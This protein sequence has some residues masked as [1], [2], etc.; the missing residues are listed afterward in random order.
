M[1]AAGLPGSI[2]CLGL[3]PACG[4]IYLIYFFLTLPMR[5][6]ERARMFLDLLELGL[7]EGRTPEAAVTGCRRHRDRSLGVR[8]HLLAAHLEQGMRLSQALEQV[9]RLLPPQV[10]A[11]LKT[12][13]R[14]GD[15]RKVLPACRLLLRDSVSEVRGA[16]NYLIL[17]ALAISPAMVTV[18]WLLR[19]CV[20]PK[21]EEVFAGML[22]GASLPA[23]TRLVFGGSAMV[24]G[25]QI[26]VIAV[27]WLATAAYLGGPRLH[28]WIHR[29]VPGAQDWALAR[30]PWRRKRL[31]RDFSAMLAVLLDAEVPEAEA[32]S[33]AAQSTANLAIIRRARKV[34]ALLQQGIKLP[35][36]LRALDDSRELQWR[37][38]NALRR[39]TGFVRALT[40]WHEALDAQA[41]QLEQSAAQVFTTVLVLVNGL[42]VASILIAVF[43]VIIQL[44][45]RGVYGDCSFPEPPPAS[46]QPRRPARRADGRVARCRGH[47][48]PACCFRCAYSF[49]SER[50]LARAYYQRAVAMEI[51]DGEMEV[52]LAGEWRDFPPGTQ[53]YRVHCGAATNLPPGRFILSVAAGQTPAPLA[54]G[55]QGPRRR[56][57]AGRHLEM[58]TARSRHLQAARAGQ[59][60]YLLIEVLVYIAVIGV[61]LGAGY[62][63]MY[64]CI[65]SSIA[66]RRVADDIT[67]ALH[68]GERWRADVRSATSPPRVENTEAGQLFYLQ[69]AQG[70]VEYS[71]ST[72]GISRRLGEGAWVRLLPNVKSSTMTADPRK[73]V[74]AWRWELE[75]RPRVTGSIKPGRVRP[76]FTFMAVPER[77][78][79]Q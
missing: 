24:T 66:L 71:F 54:A 40:G 19:V 15:I 26:G 70:A 30:L 61:V 72:N 27:L 47:C 43:L 67:S 64:H 57:H 75:L 7:Q 41:F 37:L 51:V 20:F 8:F 49:A 42:V 48:W 52:L 31:Q 63:A 56:R 28:G 60:A 77:P 68:A 58:K 44:I 12:G 21:F 16:L 1:T 59:R 65:D 36:A 17:V 2:C 9:P 74:T 10:C 55:S 3:L 23:F 13:E 38:S 46:G 50:R 45:N 4:A 5:R 6:N 76:L 78:A 39:G 35:E 73:Q 33:L 79:T 18:P 25:I 62:A 11:M 22:D 14:I 32:V 34:R 69:S 53:D 29:V